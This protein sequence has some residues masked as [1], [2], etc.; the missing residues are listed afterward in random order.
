MTKLVLKMAIPALLKTQA[1]ASVLV[2]TLHAVRAD[3]MTTTTLSAPLQDIIS[4]KFHQNNFV[5][6][7]YVKNDL[8]I[9]LDKGT[10]GLTSVVDGL[11]P[12]HRRPDMQAG[13]LSDGLSF[14]S[15]TLSIKTHHALRPELSA[16]QAT[17]HPSA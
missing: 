1:Q 11:T 3:T 9:K 17:P 12:P 15:S 6:E 14:G 8:G 2:C 4:P 10:H 16:P 13:T 7:V 5:E